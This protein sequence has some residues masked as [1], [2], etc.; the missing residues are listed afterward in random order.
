MSYDDWKLA[1]PPEY[2]DE[3]DAEDCP[4]CDFGCS[5]C[6]PNVEGG[7]QFPDTGEWPLNP[8]AGP[9]GC[10]CGFNGDCNCPFVETVP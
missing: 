9:N 10:T 5:E 8:T 6:D 3:D 1:T 4:H 7:L 2:E